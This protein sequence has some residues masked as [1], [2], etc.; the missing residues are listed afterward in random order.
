MSLRKQFFWAFS[1]ILLVILP[2]MLFKLTDHK[3]VPKPAPHAL[4]RAGR[5]FQ[6]TTGTIVN[7][8]NRYP[9]SV[10]QVTPAVKIT[11]ALQ[12]KSIFSYRKKV[13]VLMFHDLDTKGKG[14]DIITPD[15]FAAKLDYL[16]MKGIHFISLDQFR[17]F[18][19]GGQ[20]PD[21]A[22]LVTFDDGYVNFYTAAYPIM[23]K[24]HIPAV[25]FVI[26][27]DFKKTAL[28]YT[29]HMT[30]DEIY[31]MVHEDREIEVQPH[32][33]NL[34][35][36]TDR[37][38][39]ALTGLIKINGKIETRTHY[40]YRITSDLGTCIRQLSVLTPHPLDTF[41]Y[42]YGLSNRT[43]IQVLQKEGIHYAF[44]TKPGLVSRTQNPYLLPRI[45]GG[46]PKITPEKLYEAI[47]KADQIVS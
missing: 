40:V 33:D 15:Q 42:P 26:T 19:R 16:K 10:P 22:A 47:Q 8:E 32:T 4:Q 20:I 12:L 28:V 9:V 27:G 24:R 29:P 7:P 46:S 25:S 11:D 17:S 45:N 39:D 18:M 30:P 34:H 3:P 43:V 1:G 13:A 36:K 5:K 35:Y 44:T 2:F 38:H 21:N 6:Q 23:K 31:K 41:A 14:G 37:H